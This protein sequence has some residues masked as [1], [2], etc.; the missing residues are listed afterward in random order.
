MQARVLT[1]LSVLSVVSGCVTPLGEREDGGPERDA[2]AP[3]E[4]GLARDA[5]MDAPLPPDLDA[6]ARGTDAPLPRDLDAWSAP[7]DAW[8]PLGADAWS[9]PPPDAWLSPDAHVPPSAC[10]TY[11]G[12]TRPAT[13]PLDAEV[14]VWSHNGWNALG[15]AIAAEPSDCAEYWITISP[16]S[17]DSTML[18][19]GEAARMHARGESIHAIGELHWG[20]WSAYRAATGATWTEIGH[21]FRQRMVEAGYCV[22]SGDT[23]GINEAPTGARRRRPG[24]GDARVEAT[25]A[26]YAGMPGMPTA[27]GAVYVI[28]FGHGSSTGSVYKPNLESWLTDAT[29]WGQMNL[30]VR[31]WAQEVYTDPDVTCV[32]GSTRAARAT[33]INEFTMHPARLAASAPAGSGAGTAE[34]YL[35]RAY[36]PLLNAVWGSD[37]SYGHTVVPLGTMQTLISEQ[38][39]A[40]RVWADGH[41]APDG[42]IGF[43]FGSITTTEWP[44]L[45][46]RVARA[47]RGAYGRSATA[48][49]ACFEGASSVWCDCSVSGATFSS[50][51]TGF[52]TW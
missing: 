15:D 39:R 47:I 8:S 36:T 46:Q 28:N 29:F 37:G 25:A 45:A 6:Y 17:A 33:H 21:L 11:A 20:D 24:I 41:L 5:A 18:R 10:P 22:E 9:A 7:P 38:V 30:H 27:R 34:T 31:F 42:R 51:W 23:W 13:C 1:T 49:G 32:A 52:G 14:V 43:A 16:Q 3:V 19:A 4:S 2:R 26:L 48:E 40:T 35:N 12:P 44:A 50:V